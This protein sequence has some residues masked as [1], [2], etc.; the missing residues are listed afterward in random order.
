MSLKVGAR[1]GCARDI[2][3]YLTLSGLLPGSSRQMPHSRIVVSSDTARILPDSRGDEGLLRHADPGGAADA[4][5]RADGPG[6]VG[7]VRDRRGRYDACGIAQTGPFGISLRGCGGLKF[8]HEL[9]HNL[10]LSHDRYQQSYGGRLRADPA[11]GYVNRRAFEAGA[12][13][14]AR[15]RTIMSYADRCTDADV[16]CTAL[17]RFSNPRQHWNGDPL[18]VP[19]GA[20]GSAVD[21]PAD[22]AAVLAATGTAAAQWRDRPPGANRAPAAVGSLPDRT[23]AMDAPSAVDVSRAFADPDGD[24]LRYAASSSAPQVVTAF[25]TGSRVTL[26]AVGE[27]AATIH[28]TATDPGGLWASQSFAVT[29][30]RPVGGAPFT[31]NPIVPG[32]TPVRTVHFTEL[33]TRIDA[34]REAAGLA[35]FPWTD[36]VLTAG[37]TPIR[38]VHLLEL[39]RALAAAY[40]AAGQAAPG[41]T[42]ATPAA[43]RTTVRALHVTELRLAVVALE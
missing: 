15:W 11:Y 42:E 18:G 25:A 8:T 4:R 37:A 10:G 27:G 39:R 33:R 43:G 40:A 35:R 28:V 17:L 22:A 26:T 6:V 29:A 5:R 7:G 34:L 32:V 3:I 16:E 2:F 21:G 23:L 14:S 38:L 9:G 36:P 13:P 24:I 31:D 1:N 41:W 20:G 12:P 30:V 19:F